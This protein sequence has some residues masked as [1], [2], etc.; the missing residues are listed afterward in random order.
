MEQ[1]PPAARPRGSTLTQQ[2]FI[3]LLIGIA[4]AR[5]EI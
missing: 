3:G 4:A 5:G 2:I 1:S